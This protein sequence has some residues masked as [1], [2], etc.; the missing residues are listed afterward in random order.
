MAD[1]LTTISKSRL[2]NNADILSPE[3]MHNIAAAIKIQL[4]IN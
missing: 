1:Q 4:E 2:L 3:D